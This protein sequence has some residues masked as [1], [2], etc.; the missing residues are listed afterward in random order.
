MFKLKGEKRKQI[1]HY[2]QSA[3]PQQLLY[4]P[5]TF[6][7]YD[8]IQLHLNISCSSFLFIF[9]FFSTFVKGTTG[10]GRELWILIWSTK[11]GNRGNCLDIHCEFSIS[12]SREQTKSSIP[13][14]QVE[15]F[16]K[17]RG[18]K[19][20]KRSSLRIHEFEYGSCWALSVSFCLFYSIIWQRAIFA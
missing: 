17:W 7:V 20:R 19:E 16:K 6:F 10:E 2:I 18:S 15:Y 13:S 11:S 14:A 3:Q 5:C 8:I 9:F 1:R 12:K 4:H